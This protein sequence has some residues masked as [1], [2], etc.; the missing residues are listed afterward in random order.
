MIVIWGG[1]TSRTLRAHWM[2]QELDLDYQPRLIG[3]RTGE[4]QS[5]EFR[6]LN[7]KEK[8]PVLVD[9][10][11]VLTESV[12]I[13]TYL[14][15]HY[16]SQAGLVPAWK[17]VERAKYNE[18]M[19]FIQMELDAHTLYIIRKHRDLKNLYGDAPA[20]IDTAI[21][22]FNKQVQVAA[23]LLS[24]QPYLLGDTFSAA[25]LVLMTC[26]DWAHAY[27]IELAGSLL[28]LQEYRARIAPREAY[29]RAMNLNFSISAGA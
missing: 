12:A 22:G 28:S 13:V 25:D 17:T 4:T 19:S 3:S 20:A 21:T 7:P 8:I 15:D 9:G 11:L 23:D 26:L 6:L 27:G 16:G 1:A 24:T 14:G 18:W 29:Q 10:D 5:A 2:A